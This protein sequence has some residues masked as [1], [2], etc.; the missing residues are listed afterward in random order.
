MQ[1]NRT[2]NS[3]TSPSFKANIGEI[4]TK[5]IF[6]KLGKET[7]A[8]IKAFLPALVDVKNE[9]LYGDKNTFYE[10]FVNDVGM[11]GFRLGVG[12]RR[13]TG[14]KVKVAKSMFGKLIGRLLNQK[15]K[16]V[17]EI[18]SSF[19]YQGKA[20]KESFHALCTEAYGNTFNNEF[21]ENFDKEVKE[22]RQKQ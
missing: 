12:C 16:V 14:E 9:K 15:V 19:V 6:D 22:L 20:P 3:H 8:E 4:E 21:I 13:I 5:Q 1:V 2:Q 17:P 18:E 11:N 7:L 10:F